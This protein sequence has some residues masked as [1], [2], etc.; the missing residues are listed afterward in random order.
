MGKR[1]GAD[2][3]LVKKLEGKRPLGRRRRRWGII[4]KWIFKKWDV[5][6]GELIWLRMGRSGRLL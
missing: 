5:A 1:K 6:E 2:R 3:I 4:L